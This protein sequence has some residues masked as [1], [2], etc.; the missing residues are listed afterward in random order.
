MFLIVD[1]DNVTGWELN[2]VITLLQAIREEYGLTKPDVYKTIVAVLHDYKPISGEKHREKV[3]C[4]IQCNT[5]LCIFSSFNFTTMTT[6]LYCRCWIF[7]IGLLS[8]S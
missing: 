8:D 7:F 1:F 2:P 6:A 3:L 4:I 5:S